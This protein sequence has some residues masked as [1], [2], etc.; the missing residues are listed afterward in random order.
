[1]G[2]ISDLNEL[3]PADSGLQLAGC[4]PD[5]ICPSIFDNGDI[6]GFGIEPGSGCNNA[7]AC[8]TAV[9]LHVQAPIQL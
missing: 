1:M 5:A 2:P 7:V 4:P 9:L 3:I 8:G 6:A